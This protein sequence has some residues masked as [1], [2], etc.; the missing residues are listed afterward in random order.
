MEVIETMVEDSGIELNE[1]RVDGGASAN[2]LLMQI[3]SD[4]I[5]TKVVRPQVTETTALGAAYLAGLAVGY[6]KSI[7]EVKKQWHVDEIFNPVSD[8]TT[9]KE[10]IVNWKRATELSKNWNK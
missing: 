8:L 10:V 4:S 9:I 3:Q 7:E 2:N 6:W 5:N 1:L